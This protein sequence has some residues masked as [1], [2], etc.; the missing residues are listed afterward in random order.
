[1]DMSHFTTTSDFAPVRLSYVA[2]LRGVAPRGRGANFSYAQVGLNNPENFLCLAASNPEGLFYA[3]VP[4]DSDAVTA[5]NTAN[6]RNV[7]NAFFVTDIK[8]LPKLDYIV[9]DSVENPNTKYSRVEFGGFAQALVQPGGL[10]VYRYK[11]HDNVDEILR[12][13]VN[14]FSPE[15][16]PD[17]A[18]VF[19]QEIKALGSKY[20][21]DHTIA[22]AALDNAIA[23][24]NPG[25]FF[26]TCKAGNKTRSGTFDVMADFVP[27]NFV[28]AGDADISS[29][30][31]EMSVP[32]E[33]QN[34]LMQCQG[35]V[36]YETI[37]DFVMQRLTRCDIW[38]R[39]PVKQTDNIVSLYSS[40]TFG[41]TTPRELVPNEVV[42]NGKTI[43]LRF[44]P[45][46]GLID[47]MSSLPLSIGDFMHSDAGK[48]IAPPDVVG[49]VQVLVA[50]GIATPMRSYYQGQDQADLTHPRWATGFNNYLNDSPVTKSTV[51]LASPVVGGA[52][53]VSARDALV[54]QALNRAGMADSITALLPELVRISS[55]PALAAQITD[56]AEPTAESAHNMINEVVN[57][58]M[59][60]WYAYGLLAA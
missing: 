11:A 1:M 7:D 27:R 44:A 25:Q 40:F 37:K 13:L 2:A 52:V 58:S 39:T 4:K 21:E 50:S 23:N 53:T 8:A 49:A 48:M 55:D 31:L 5:K 32:T 19:L 29:N 20:F 59:I 41:I 24:K 26:D 45:F 9:C 57:R 47:L 6:A 10:M 28:Y 16:G 35:N 54:I 56:V 22:R 18:Q 33:A 36:L 3:V 46:P 43:N 17:D 15:M 51:L 60:K 30:Y 34:L 38:C 12:F 14:E 42:V